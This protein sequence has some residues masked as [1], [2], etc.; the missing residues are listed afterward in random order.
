[1]KKKSKKKISRI[2]FKI[3]SLCLGIGIG[4]VFRIA[5]GSE[6]LLKAA[7]QSAKEKQ[8]MILVSHRAG[9]AYA[10]ENTVAALERSIA[11]GASIAESDVQ[12]LADGTLIVMHDSNFLRKAGINRA[13]WDTD[14]EEVLEWNTRW[15]FGT[16]ME[17]EAIPTLDEMLDVAG[18]RICLMIELKKTGHET[19]LEDSVVELLNRHQLEDWCIIGS[20]DEE[21]LQ[22]IKALDEGITTVLISHRIEP[23][24]YELSYADSYS[25]EAV[26]ISPKLVESLHSQQKLLYGWTVNSYQGMQMVLDAGADGIVTD[27]IPKGQSFL[28]RSERSVALGRFWKN[29]K[30][31]FD[32]RED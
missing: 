31:F 10:A 6:V 26:N 20:F 16:G 7:Q 25:V 15:E 3:G 27:D 23:E 12:Q 14:W 13:V 30:V 29:F 11:D 32:K 22:N 18:R 28:K 19:D 2:H 24:Q 1:M 17:R 8:P 9:A 5:L 4:I 21:I